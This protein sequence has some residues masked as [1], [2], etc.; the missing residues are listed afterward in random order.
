MAVYR[1]L[2]S[3]LV[4]LV[5]A[6]CGTF[7]SKGEPELGFGIRAFEDG[8]HVYAARLLQ[9]SLDA[10][11]RGTSNRASAHKYLAFIHCASSRIQQCRDEFKMALEVDSSFDLRDDEAGHPIWGPAFRSVK[12]KK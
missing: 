12:P 2:A 3:L 1:S 10:G 6:G 5:M 11:L 4:C 8:E 7:S 9:L